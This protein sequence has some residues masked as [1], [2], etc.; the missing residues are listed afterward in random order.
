[1]RNRRFDGT[2]T[3]FDQETVMA[4]CVCFYEPFTGFFVYFQGARDVV[5]Y[6]DTTAESST[7]P[8]RQWWLQPPTPPARG[9]P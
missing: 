1:M 3:P 5:A 2:V 6:G 7:L 8:P 4:L 9:G